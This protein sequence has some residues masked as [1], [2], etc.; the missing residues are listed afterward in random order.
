M[1][2]DDLVITFQ[3]TV[4]LILVIG[5]CVYLGFTYKWHKTLEDREEEGDQYDDL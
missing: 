1:Y 3:L 4:N 2:E 5:L